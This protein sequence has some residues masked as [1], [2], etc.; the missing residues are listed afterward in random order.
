MKGLKTIAAKFA[1][2]AILSGMLLVLLVNTMLNGVDG[3][4]EEFTAE[5]A[6]VNGLR[7]GDDVRAAGVRVGK[8]TSIETTGEIARVQ[9]EVEEDQAIHANTQLVMRYRDLVGQR[10]IALVQTGERGP[11]LDAGATIDVQYTDPGFDLTQLLNGFRPLFEVLNPADVN[12]LAESLVK[13]LQGEGGT[14]EQLL[15]QTAELSDFIADRDQIIGEVITN[16][17]PV[18]ENLAGQGDE[19]TTTVNELRRLMEGLAA[20]REAIGDSID[21]ISQ[22]VGSTSDLLTEVR[23]PMTGTSRELKEVAAMLR[24]AEGDLEQA[25]PAFAEIFRGL[26]KITSYENAL[27]IYVC[28]LTMHTAGVPIDFAPGEKQFSEVCRA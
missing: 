21:G 25:L 12:T 11:E 13:V 4:T 2:F 23:E 16:L 8:V 1:A 18:L 6:D 22:L 14:V 28:T 5:F 15:A 10:Y 7:N 17:V 20:D 26:G 9:I 27:N 3:D 24:N 19:I